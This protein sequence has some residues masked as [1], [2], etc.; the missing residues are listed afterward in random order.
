MAL[1]WHDAESFPDDELRFQLDRVAQELTRLEQERSS[2]QG[3]EARP[4]PRGRAEILF[5]LIPL[6]RHRDSRP[7]LAE[8][9]TELLDRL[10]RGVAEDA[11]ALTEDPEG[12]LLSDSPTRCRVATQ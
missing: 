4:A 6:A 5:D 10:R 7:A 2:A 8:T 3:S 9:A 11:L 12:L 1:F